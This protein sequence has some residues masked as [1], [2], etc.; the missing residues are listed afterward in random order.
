M[1][2]PWKIEDGVEM[3]WGV[4]PGGD[5]DSSSEYRA[6]LFSCVIEAIMFIGER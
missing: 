2:S 1:D 4:A 6:Y 3:E 5:V